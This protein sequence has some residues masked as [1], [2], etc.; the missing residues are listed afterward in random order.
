M[1]T[2]MCFMLMLCGG[3]V[4]MQ[5]SGCC[6][7]VVGKARAIFRS[8]ERR[9]SLLRE[10]RN[11]ECSSGTSLI[12]VF[13]SHDHFALERVNVWKILLIRRNVFPRRGLDE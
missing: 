7:R 1:L 13:M 8:A 4:R 11:F 12:N 10:W 6:Q 2:S 9:E 3:C 5:L